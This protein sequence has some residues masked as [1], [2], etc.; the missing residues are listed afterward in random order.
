MKNIYT[1]LY[2]RHTLDLSHTPRI[3]IMSDII[4]SIKLNRQKILDIGCHDG[5]F[6]SLI[7]GRNFLFGIEPSETAYRL[8]LKKNIKLTKLLIDDHTSLPYPDNYFDIVITGEIIEHVYDTDHFLQ[9]IHR[10]L[11]PRGKLLLS[12]PNL[13]SFGRRLMLLFGINPIIENSP[14]RSESAG[15]IRYF[16]K[17]TLKELLKS[18]KFKISVYHSDVVNFTP[19]GNLKSFT[20][21][22]IF[23]TLGQSII[24]LCQKQK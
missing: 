16:I 22:K 17:D 13:A 23:P 8:A 12:T 1:N 15:H 10:V 7:K 24:V 21:A 18:N 11:K 14:N 9:E 20:L 19:S 5:Y 2:D 3:K 4:N 6:L